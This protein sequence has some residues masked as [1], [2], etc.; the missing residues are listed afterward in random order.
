MTLASGLG[1]K[2]QES[3]YWKVDIENHSMHTDKA[4][5][6]TFVVTGESQIAIIE[7]V[8]Y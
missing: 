4:S 3:C 2:E 5:S 6:K 8:V 1:S 7:T